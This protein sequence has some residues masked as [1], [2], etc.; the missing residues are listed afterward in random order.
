MDDELK[1]KIWVSDYNF[2]P[3]V[4][5][6]FDYDGTVQ[7]YDTTLR[8][9]EQ[10]VGVVLHPDEKLA[11]ARKLDELGIARIEGGFPVVSDEDNKAIELLNQADLDAEIW[12][13]S[14]AVE[15]DVD[16]LLELGTPA[17][18]IE[19]PTSDLKLDAYDISRQQCL[20]RAV[21]AVSHATENGMKV[22]FFTV[23]GTRTEMDFLK[24]IY[25]ATVDAGAEEVVV[26]DTIGVAG[27]EVIEW[28]VRQVRSWVGDDVPIHFH[29]QNDFGLAT[30]SSVAA[31]R[32]GA[33]WIQ[34]TINGMG[35][36]AGNADLGEVG[37]ALQCLYD[38]PVEMKFEK[39]RETSSLVQDHSNYEMAPWK[40]IVG[41]NLFTR[42]SGAVAHQFHIPNAIEPYSSD[43]VGAERNIV[44]GKKSGLA[45]IK[46]KAEELGLS[47]PEDKRQAILNRV[48][49]KGIEK[50]ELLTDDEFKEIVNEELD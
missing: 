46:I 37:M 5:P 32:G 27:P 40:P 17:A 4:K 25:Q 34:G 11:I 20:D 30:A 45:S 36:R 18:V 21:N 29:G 47:I 16:V 43:L 33:E 15:S 41:R 44:L 7:L 39:I 24:D 1:E 23:D 19:V 3:D 35:E 9:G 10:T 12:G 42:E 26:V 13:F 31:V 28:M 48:K 8:D 22:A 49:Q 38:V 14:R 6:S 50:G 2:D